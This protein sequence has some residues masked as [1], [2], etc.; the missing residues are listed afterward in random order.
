M[1]PDLDLDIF[2]PPA[3][4]IVSAPLPAKLTP[5]RFRQVAIE[6]RLHRQVAYHRTRRGLSVRPLDGEAAGDGVWIDAWQRGGDRY[7]HWLF[8]VWPK[9][10]ALTRVSARPA[11]GL[12]LNDCGDRLRSETLAALGL[13]GLAVRLVD[14]KGPRLAA[15][16]VLQL[17][18]GRDALYTPPWIIE[19]VR[20]AFLPSASGSSVS[21]GGG[22][23]LYL[24][25][26]A[27]A[28]RKVVNEAQVEAFLAARGFETVRA[29]EMSLTE[30][31]ALMSHASVVAGPHG[32]GLANVVFCPEQCRVVEL[33]SHHISPEY[34][35]L[36]ARMGL[37]YVAVACAGP[38]GRRL[39]D[40]PSE[41]AADRDLC[42][43]VDIVV[44]LIQ[45]AQALDG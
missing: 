1:D 13:E 26:S 30:V 45:L 29:E 8:D 5:R 3:P 42:N 44:D 12:I 38:D 17:D 6:S 40:L 39:H 27:A 18:G 28:R 34:W 25:R 20:S 9:L 21:A 7:S 2:I 23:R 10:Q 15:D 31:A 22:R 11:A 35:L 36:C 37:D 19:A 4:R 24:S 16:T 32:A 43:P 33:F 14:K 41:T